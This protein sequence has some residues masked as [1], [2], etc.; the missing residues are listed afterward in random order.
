MRF[1]RDN[2]QAAIREA[3]R[4]VAAGRP[5]DATAI[6]QRSLDVPAG[7]MGAG[8]ISWTLSD[9]LREWLG[10]AAPPFTRA[11]TQ[12]RPVAEPEPA[13]AAGQFLSRSYRNGSGTRGYR[14]YV[15]SGYSGQAVPLVVMLHGC[16]QSP[17]DFAAG[18]RMN[19]HAEELACLAAYPEQS[20]AANGSRCW[21]WFRPQDQQRGASRRSLPASPSR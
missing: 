19:A 5:G 18:T 16:K 14:L 3:S 4:L 2:S 11:T 6:L 15:P 10:R 7:D 21:N 12:A 13:P 9:R 8:R 1:D 17:E 20:A